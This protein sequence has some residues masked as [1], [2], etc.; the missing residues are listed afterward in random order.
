MERVEIKVNGRNQMVD[1]F[2]RSDQV[3]EQVGWAGQT[4]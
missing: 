4:Q 1:N 2:E 3:G